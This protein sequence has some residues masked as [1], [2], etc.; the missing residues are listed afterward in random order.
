[1]KTSTQFPKSAGWITAKLTVKKGA[2]FT[3]E[4]A[5]SFFSFGQPHRCQFGLIETNCN[6]VKVIYRETRK[7]A[8]DPD[9]QPVAAP[10]DL[11]ALPVLPTP[12]IA[13]C[14]NLIVQ[15]REVLE[16]FQPLPMVR[17]EILAGKHF[18]DAGNYGPGDEVTIGPLTDHWQIL[19][20]PDPI[21]A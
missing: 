13:R 3:E 17:V 7:A 8:L 18:N 10:L 6:P 11:E 4:D 9:T 15:V 1:M 2:N 19:T 5:R 12:F 16:R 20:F 21:P 14:G